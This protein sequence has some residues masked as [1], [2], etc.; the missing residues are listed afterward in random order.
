[1]MNFIQGESW[2]QEVKLLRD[3]VPVDVGPLDKVDDRVNWIEVILKVNTR[4]QARYRYPLDEANFPDHD[5]L[6]VDL[7][8]PN[9]LRLKITR[10]QSRHFEPG[11]LTAF[12]YINFKQ[13]GSADGQTEEVIQILG[14]MLRSDFAFS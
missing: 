13:A 4:E 9:I 10:K 3:G 12:T 1:M 11:Y 14:Y 2:V 8:E 6:E 5:L 7:W